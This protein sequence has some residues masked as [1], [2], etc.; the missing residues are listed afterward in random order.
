MMDDYESTKISSDWEEFTREFNHDME[1]L[2]KSLKN[3][4][5]SN[6]K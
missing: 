5:V 4:T 2:G 3:L 1:E 6:K